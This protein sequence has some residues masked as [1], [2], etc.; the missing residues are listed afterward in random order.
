MELKIEYI[1][2]EDLKPY[3]RNNKKHADFDVGEIA[4]SIEKYG[5]N[6]PIGIYG[7]NIIVEGHGRLLAAKKLGMETVPCIRLDHMTDKERRE[8]AILHNKTAELAEY[9]F[10][11]IELELPDL[12]FSDFDIDFGLDTI[13]PEFDNEADNSDADDEWD[14]ERHNERE[15]TFETYNL[16]QVDLSRTAGKYQM[17]IIKKQIFNAPKVLSSF[18]NAI[19]TTDETVKQCGVH[20]FSDDYK[21]E[22]IWAD[23][24]KYAE[25]LTEFE[26]ALTPD[27]SLYLDMP[28][29]MKIWNVYRSRLIGQVMQD[30]GIKVVPTVQWAEPETFEFCFDGIEKG[31]ICA[32]STIGVKRDENATDIWRQGVAEMIKRVEPTAI[33]CYGG[34]IGYDFGDIPVTY[35]ENENKVRLT[36]GK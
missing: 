11:N 29:A 8:Y 24:D 25:K 13:M 21:F 30:Y 36:N 28:M 23:P 2:V 16:Y 32:I 19:N 22:R 35:W 9:D 17:P 7:K 10:V 14:S 1:P 33:W 31:S 3:E 18:T 34:D 15:R 5:F 26:C 20:F 27:F 4:K 12:D 6:D